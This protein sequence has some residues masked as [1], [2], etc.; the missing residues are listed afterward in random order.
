[1][2][3][4]GVSGHGHLDLAAYGAFLAGELDD[5]ELSQDELD[6]AIKG[7]PEAPAIA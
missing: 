7:L 4:I 1:V 2:I 5:L 6:T 3:L